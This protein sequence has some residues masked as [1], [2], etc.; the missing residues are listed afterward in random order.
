[1]ISPAPILTTE[2]PIPLHDSMT[3][4]LFS[5]IWK[6][7]RVLVF[8]PGIFITRSSIVSG[9]L[10]LMSFARTK[11][12]LHSS[13][14]S[15]VSVGNGSRLPMS[16]SP[17]KTALM[18]RVNS[19]L[20]S[21]LIVCV[22]FAFDPWTWILPLTLPFEAW[23]WVAPAPEDAGPGPVERRFCAVDPARNLEISWQVLEELRS[24]TWINWLRHSLRA[25]LAVKSRDLLPSKLVWQHHT[26]DFRFAGWL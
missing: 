7:F 8:R 21:S 16:G 15:N 2:H 4:L 18:W 19:V 23:P 20:S 22:V 13:N 3:M 26:A 12:S 24:K 6:A 10:S 1:M 17:A 9:T 14:I 25:L 5:L 11:P